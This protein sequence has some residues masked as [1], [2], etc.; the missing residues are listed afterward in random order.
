MVNSLMSD[1]E[2]AFFEW[3][4]IEKGPQRYRLPRD[5][6]LVLDGVFWIARTGTGWRDLHRYFGKWDSV[7][8]QFRRWML[9]GIWDVMLKA[10]NDAGAGH[11]SVQMIDSTVI[12]AHQHAAGAL[13]NGDGDQ[14][15]G[16]SH[17]GFSTKI[18]LRSNALGL[19]V[20]ITL[21]GGQ[22]SDVKGY[23]PIME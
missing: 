4:V 10:L 12:R 16:C 22:V 11:D 9:A 23:G 20:A 6:R 1:K 3:F 5:Y 14:G 13:K 7:Y 17:E 18:H 2:W 8:W 19:P 21:S 15:L